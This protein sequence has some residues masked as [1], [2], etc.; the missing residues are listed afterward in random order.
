MEFRKVKSSVAF[1]VVAA[2]VLLISQLA[3]AGE[4]NGI[5]QGVVKD[6]AGKPV[7]GAFVKLKNDSRRLEFMVISQSQGRYTA[8]DLPAGEYTVQGVGNGFQSVWSAPVNAAP[9]K[10]AK[11]DLSLT[12]QQGAAL[13]HAW[14]YK[15][16]EADLAALPK[17]LPEGDAKKLLAN[18]CTTCHGVDRIMSYHMDREHWDHTVMGM[19]ANMRTGKLRDLSDDEAK[20]A[21]D[22]LT[23]NFKPLRS[24]DPNDRLP[25]TLLDGK[26]LKYRVVQYSL[27]DGYAEPHDV[28]VDPRGN[29]W[30]AERAGR[31]GHLDPTTLAF[32]EIPIPPGPARPDS[33][34]LGN[35]QIDA[36]GMMWLPDGPNG[37]W[38][39][40][41]TSSGEFTTYDWP[42]TARAGAGGNTVAVHPNGTIWQTGAN[43]ARMLNPVTKEWKFFETPTLLS[44]GEATGA[45]GMAVAGDGKVWFAEDLVD[46]MAKIDPVTGKVEEL[47]IPFDG[48]AYPRRMNSDAHG[49]LWV[50][51]WNG[52]RLMKIDYETDKMT[53]YKPPTE[54]PGTYSVSVDK[55]NNLIWVSEQQAD[56]IARFNPATG[57]WVEFPLP[58]SESDPRRIEVDQNH[59]NRVWWTG[60]LAARMGFIEI[61]Q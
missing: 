48:V 41:S 10:A 18:R 59:P 34:R 3:W 24:P 26:T 60:N 53:L 51:L 25:R 12:T 27:T 55:K 13:P 56:K 19:R 8:S 39:S 47:K 49:D 42:K 5:I 33:Q 61:L 54:T 9:G 20:Q 52:G 15:T 23:A 11:L 14:P 17:D 21:V 35:P 46:R 57:E 7:S 44:G 40:Y 32:T 45:Y 29:G 1:V 31:I 16:P 30:V 4:N 50:G 37:R 38:L 43:G 36:K 22:Y 2:V 58:D 28:A 6:S